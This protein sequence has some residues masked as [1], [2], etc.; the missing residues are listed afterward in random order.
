MLGLRHRRRQ[1]CSEGV[2][3]D[4]AGAFEIADSDGDVVEAA[5]HEALPADGTLTSY[6]DHVHVARWLF[7]PGM[8]HFRPHRA[9]DGIRDRI[10]VAPARLG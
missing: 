3:V 9:L 7:A 10:G 8:A 4:G 5:D 6:D 1:A 2:P